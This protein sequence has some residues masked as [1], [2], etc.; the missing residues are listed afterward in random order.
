MKK[1]LTV[2]AV[3]GAFALV[4]S[5]ASAFH[6]LLVSCDP[7]DFVPSGVT[8]KKGLTCAEATN[9]LAITVGTKTAN[10][11]DGC[12]YN[13]AAPWSVWEAGKWASKISAANAA[14]IAQMEIKAKGAAFG[15]CNLSGSTNGA[16]AY[17]AG[18]F[19]FLD[20]SGLNKVKGGK[21][22][23]I[24]RVG[25]DVPT[26]SAILNG[27]VNKGFGVGG[28]IKVQVGLDTGDPGN[29]NL[30]ACNT[31]FLCPP[32]AFNDPNNPID[33][34]GFIVLQ[35]LPSS[36][37]NIGYPDDSDC[38]AANDPFDCCTGAGTGSCSD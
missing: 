10:A 29:D 17:M 5:M 1:R 23:F 30:L 26:S 16:S 36:V 20:V 3:A 31:G 9:K 13:A 2:L 27:I 28:L 12:A 11:V 34:I 8:V 35:T 6:G 33:P 4:P 25:A 22:A 14:L 18:K 32:D 24:S 7:T 19:T 38:A 21:G 15:S 37:A